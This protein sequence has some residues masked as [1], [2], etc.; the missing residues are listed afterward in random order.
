M[1]SVRLSGNASGTGILTVASPNT[2]SNRTLTLPDNTG[3]LLSTASAGTVLQVVQGSYS[4]TTSTS[5]GTYVTSGLTASITPSS[6]SSKILVIV[7][8]LGGISGNQ[9]VNSSGGYT[10]ARSGTQISGDSV[11]RTYD[12]S[13]SYGVYIS[14]PICLSYLDSP[15]TTSSTAY[16]LYLK[17][18]A[19]TSTYINGDGG[20]SY[21][22][23]MEI[24]A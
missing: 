14:T 11:L 9:G 4:T 22:T 6:S 17:T 3:T 18:Y 8:A 10:I 15:A 5:S 1:S 7:A 19:S 20:T 23:L 12:Y 2:N 24:A 16:A 13:G 21:I